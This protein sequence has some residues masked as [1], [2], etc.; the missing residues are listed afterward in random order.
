MK[1]KY[2]ISGVEGIKDNAIID[3]SIDKETKKQRKV[4]LV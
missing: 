3:F 2:I 1:G 4:W